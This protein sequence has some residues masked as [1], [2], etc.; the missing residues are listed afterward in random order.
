MSTRYVS[1]STKHKAR[2]LRKNLTNA[3]QLLWQNIRRK[4]L[5]VKFRRQVS[6]GDYIVDFYCVS[7]QL[8]VEVDGGQ[9]LDNKYDAQRTAFLE[10][11]GITVVRY[12]NNQVLT[13]TG[14]VVADL[15][16][17]A[18]RLSGNE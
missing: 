14:E 17:H 11:Q 3:E 13:E 18:A 10:E 12:W 2:T 7:C 15:F 9:H 1:L 16:R 8:A 6:I 5:G 4:Q